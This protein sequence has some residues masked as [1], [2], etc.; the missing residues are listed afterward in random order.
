MIKYEKA[1]GWTASYNESGINNKNAKGIYRSIDFFAD[2][3][4]D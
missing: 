4:S 1:K 3:E 2:Y